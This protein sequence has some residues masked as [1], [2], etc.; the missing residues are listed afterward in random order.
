MG[1]ELPAWADSHSDIGSDKKETSL[2]P[3]EVS[4]FLR[5]REGCH[6]DEI[7]IKASCLMIPERAMEPSS[8]TTWAMLV[9]GA[10]SHPLTPPP[11]LLP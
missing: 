5:S 11:S 2:A 8:F 10:L 9:V 7:G 6:R 3:E 1:P 4:F